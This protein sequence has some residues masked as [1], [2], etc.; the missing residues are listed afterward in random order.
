MTVDEALAFFMNE[1]TISRA[2]EMLHEAALPEL[3]NRRANFV[4]EENQR[5]HE[6]ALALK[7]KNTTRVADLLKK[8]HEGLQNQYEV[9]CEELDTLAIFANQYPGVYGARMMGGGFGGCVIC[10]VKEERIES[11]LK[12]IM[13]V[14]HIKFNFY[15]ERIDFELSNGVEIL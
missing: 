9:S 4:I 10:L 1:P 14:Y 8:S 6:M 3:L 15:P 12:E 7:E 11:F 5:V 13:E 2:L